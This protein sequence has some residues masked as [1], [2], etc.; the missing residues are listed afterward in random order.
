MIRSLLI[1]AVVAACIILAISP[2]AAFGFTDNSSTNLKQ[3]N[4][5]VLT[6]RR[7][8][9]YST[10]ITIASWTGATP[11]I[12]PVNAID[13]ESLPTE[14]SKIVEE[15]T[16]KT[17]VDSASPSLFAINVPQRFFSIRRTSKGDLP[18]A[19]TGK[20]RRGGTIFSAGDMAKAEVIAVERYVRNVVICVPQYMM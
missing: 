9:I 17:F 3:N 20:G 14:A 15:V 10:A 4:L 8:F 2:A 11:F 16:M 1:T 7:Q 18:D 13:V 6:Q 12:S 5:E 19:K